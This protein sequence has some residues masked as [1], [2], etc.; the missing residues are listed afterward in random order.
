MLS[1]TMISF[2]RTQ[3]LEALEEN[4]CGD[5]GECL[6]Y[7]LSKPGYTGGEE[8]GNPLQY[9]CLENPRDGGA[10]WD[11]VYWAAQSQTQLKQLSSSSSRIHRPPQWLSGQESTYNA[12]DAAGA[13][14]QDNPLEKEMATHLPGKSRCLGS[15]DKIY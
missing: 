7:L 6:Y 15:W 8:N 9:S 12:G 10:W 13:V 14:G 11:A 2:S 5:E 1:Y 3:R 4:Q